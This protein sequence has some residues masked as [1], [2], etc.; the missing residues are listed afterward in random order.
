M[1]GLM[2]VGSLCLEVARTCLLAHGWLHVGGEEELVL[3]IIRYNVASGLT[4]GDA[5][6]LSNAPRALAA[7]AQP[8]SAPLPLEQSQRPP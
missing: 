8:V 5:P 3:V 4:A 7:A 2:A 1:L 6:Y